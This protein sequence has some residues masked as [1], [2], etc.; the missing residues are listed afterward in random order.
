LNVTNRFGADHAPVGHNAHLTDLKAFFKPLN[1]GQRRCDIGR[2]AGPH[3]ATDGLP[4]VIDNGTHHHL[5]KI[6]AMVLAKASLPDTLTTATLEV[7]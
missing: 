6:R 3:L 4:L 2:I 1:D 7:D 5:Y